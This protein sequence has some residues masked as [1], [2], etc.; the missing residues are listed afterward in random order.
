MIMN[1][2]LQRAC[3]QIKNLKMGIYDQTYVGLQNNYIYWEERCHGAEAAIS[4]MDEIIHNLQTLY[5]EWRDKYTNMAVL[6]D[7]A[8]QDFPDKLKEVDLIMCPE[9]TPEEVYHFVKLYKKTMSELITNIEALRKSQ[10]VA[11]K[12]DI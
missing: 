6:T 4:Q 2:P 8:L 1:F 3:K 12:I 10:G 9:N 5:N 11:F 7:Y